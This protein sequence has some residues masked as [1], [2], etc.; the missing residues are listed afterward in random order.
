MKAVF[1]DRDGTIAKD[2]HYCRRVEDFEILPTVPEAIKLLNENGFK[3]IVITN[4]SGIARGY[5]TEEILSKIHQ[6]MINELSKYGA[7]IDAIYYCPHHPDDGCDCRKP[8]TA[9]FHKAAKKFNIDFKSSYVVGDR[10]MDIDAGRALGCKTILV[11]TGPE[12]RGEIIGLP[13]YTADNLLQAAKWI[14]NDSN[15]YNVEPRTSNV[16]RNKP[17]NRQTD[18]TDKPLT[19]IIIPAYNE[20]EGLSVVLTK[21][22][23]IIDKTYEVIVVDDGSTDR[24]HEVASQFPCRVIR[25]KTNKGKGEALK[26]GIKYAEG[27][28][29]IWIDADDT[30]PSELIPKMAKALKDNYDMVVGSRYFGRNNIPLFNRLG[31]WFF[32]NMIK[33]IYGFKAFDPC[34]GLYGVKKCHLQKMHLSSR[35]FAIEPE[36]SIKGSRMK[37]KTLDIPT[38]YHPRIGGSKLSAVKV[39]F[40]DLK[41]IISHVFWYPPKEDRINRKVSNYE[42]DF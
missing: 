28:N 18:L 25:H 22:F 13:D 6:K 11:N 2:V 10:Q 24:T 9:L 20:E 41:T 8:K 23:N 35:R 32:R 26:I 3:V 39:G 34:S 38:T 5:F 37:L 31:N 16:E 17:I 12:D 19:T 4:Q 15:Q 42:R 21:I 27:K 1:L 40:E 7:Q 33:T 30:Y 29:I 14:V 36:I